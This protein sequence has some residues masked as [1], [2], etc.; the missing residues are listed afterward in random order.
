LSLLVGI[1]FLVWEHQVNFTISLPLPL[2]TSRTKRIK[3]YKKEKEPSPPTAL[4]PIRLHGTDFHVS[5]KS[6]R[7]AMA[8]AGYEDK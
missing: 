3:G 4:S 5:K 6:G 8:A 1:V 2:A 7:S